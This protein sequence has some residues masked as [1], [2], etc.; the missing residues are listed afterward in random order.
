MYFTGMNQ[1]VVG[2]ALLMMPS[3]SSLGMCEEEEVESEEGTEVVILLHGLCRSSRS[4][5]RIEERLLDKGYDVLNLDYA[6][7][8]KPHG[9]DHQRRCG[10]G[11]M[12]VLGPGL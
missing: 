10:Q 9:C 5:R 12:L 8:R 4:M 2:L 1:L 7:T 6:S 3:L 11:R